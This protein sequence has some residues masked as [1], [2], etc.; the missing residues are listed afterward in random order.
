MAA[1]FHVEVRGDIAVLVQEGAPLFEETSRS[2]AAVITTALE[3]GSK[4]IIIDARLSDL[5]N[6]YNYVVRHAELLPTI[7]FDGSFRSA[8]VGLPE[9]IDVMDFIV[10]VGRNRGWTVRRF[11][12]M[13]EAP[14]WLANEA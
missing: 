6:Y 9:Q 11:L 2:L 10:S 4:K 14:R 1:R 3:I 12:D 5:V 7:G 8:I 13:D